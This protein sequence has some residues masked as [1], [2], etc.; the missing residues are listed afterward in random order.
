[1]RDQESEIY[2]AYLIEGRLKNRIGMFKTRS[3]QKNFFW[4]RKLMYVNLWILIDI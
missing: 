3:K 1:M 2:N 4:T